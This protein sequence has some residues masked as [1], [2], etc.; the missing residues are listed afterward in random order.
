MLRNS[1]NFAELREVL[2]LSVASKP[3]SRSSSVEKWPVLSPPFAAEGDL[4]S[5][6]GESEQQWRWT[7]QTKDP[8]KKRRDDA[9]RFSS[10]LDAVSGSGKTSSE[11]PKFYK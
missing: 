5:I 8:K 1:R 3:L 11:N 10:L 7:S 6:P 4:S 2:A 9:G